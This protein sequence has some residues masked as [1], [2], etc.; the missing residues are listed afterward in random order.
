MSHRTAYVASP[1]EALLGRV[2]PHHGP[3][4]TAAY[5]PPTP[6]TE[7]DSDGDDYELRQAEALLARSQKQNGAGGKAFD[8]PST[9]RES[10]L[11]SLHN[12]SRILTQK[13][14]ARRLVYLA[15]AIAIGTITLYGAAAHDSASDYSQRTLGSLGAAPGR[16]K[17]A[18]YDRFSSTVW[19]LYGTAR[20]EADYE[21]LNVSH[22]SIPLLG[23]FGL[24]QL[25]TAN[26]S[27]ADSQFRYAS[28]NAEGATETGSAVHHGQC[29]R[30][31]R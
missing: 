24:T 30:R 25:R 27:V 3:T 31:A 10:I 19:S 22:A 14:I 7:T 17:D 28:A 23:G 16:L 6:Q 4:P 21:P 11:A 15:V 9:T 2:F 20:L 18:V 12:W 29:V 8:A 26:P 1:G 5:P 13:S